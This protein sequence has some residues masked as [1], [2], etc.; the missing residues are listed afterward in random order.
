MLTVETNQYIYLFNKKLSHT[1]QTPITIKQL[2]QE[3]LTYKPND[4]KAINA[5][6]F[7]MIT[8]I[9]VDIL[10]EFVLNSNLASSTK[11]LKNYVVQLIDQQPN[12]YKEINCA[13][14]HVKYE[15]IG[16]PAHTN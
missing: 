2:A 15:L 10:K 6:R 4:Y 3:L 8:E 16:Q 5:A 1:V 14:L 7:R 12:E 13:Y 11:S 9:Y